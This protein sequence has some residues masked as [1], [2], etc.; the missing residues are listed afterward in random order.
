MQDMNTTQFNNTMQDMN[1]TQFTNTTQAD[2][3]KKDRF[4][5]LSNIIHR[6]Q[7]KTNHSNTTEI[8]K[9]YTIY[10][11]ETSSKELKNTIT[12]N[13][14]LIPWLSRNYYHKQ[15]R[16]NVIYPAAAKLA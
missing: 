1:T 7:K 12:K 5:T 13:E 16:N 15:K 4:I 11:R 6:T 14:D 2:N 8:Q 9:Y 10:D 3:T